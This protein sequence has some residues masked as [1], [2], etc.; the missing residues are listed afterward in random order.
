MSLDS[1]KFCCS[2]FYNDLIV[3][4]FLASSTEAS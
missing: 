2:Q 3:S 1:T 4:S